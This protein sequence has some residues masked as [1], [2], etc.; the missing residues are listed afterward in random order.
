MPDQPCPAP[1][2]PPTPHGVVC[3][4]W[5]FHRVYEAQLPLLE[6]ARP[7]GVMLHGSAVGLVALAAEYAGRLRKDLSYEP[8]IWLGIAAD[9]DKGPQAVERW[10]SVA[11]LA[12]QIE[13]VT[14]QVNAEGRVE[15][16]DAGEIVLDHRWTEEHAPHVTAAFAAMRAAAPGLP[17]GHTSWPD[18]DWFPGYPWAAFVG[19]GGADYTQPQCYVRGG[20]RA[21]IMARHD[22]ALREYEQLRQ[23][24]D[25]AADCDVQVYLAASDRN[26]PAGTLTVGPRCDAV[27]LWALGEM[28]DEGGRRTVIGLCQLR[29]LGYHGPNAIARFQRAVGL[30][31]DGYPGPLTQRALGLP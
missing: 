15:R 31:A 4:L 10:A 30:E 17:L 18:I 23:R 8:Q 20:G 26:D 5:P 9:G 28:T 2:R 27:S 22:N 19:S 14:V 3:T 6:L 13:A 29:R 16:D 1:T 7:Q 21:A 25:L 24:G 11:E 12:T